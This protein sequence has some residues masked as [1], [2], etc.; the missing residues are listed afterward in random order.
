MALKSLETDCVS[1][2]FTVV[3]MLTTCWRTTLAEGADEREAD[4]HAQGRR[5]CALRLGVQQVVELR[6]VIR[7]LLLMYGR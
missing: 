7:V 2:S 4:V 1:R 6:R 3:L 5:A